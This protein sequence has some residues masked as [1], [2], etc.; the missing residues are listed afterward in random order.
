MRIL[1]ADAQK[2]V[3]AVQLYLSPQEARS[4][5]QMLGRLLRDPEATEHEHL[6]SDD[7]GAELSFSIVTDTRPTRVVDHP[8]QRRAIETTAVVVVPALD[9]QTSLL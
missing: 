3:R 1:D 4:F 9:M 2:P 5:A 6:V 8:H 7:M